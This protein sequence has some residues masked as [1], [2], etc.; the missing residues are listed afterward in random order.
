MAEARSRRS[1]SDQRS[2]WVRAGLL[3]RRSARP[4]DK[5]EVVLSPLLH[6]E[7]R[8]QVA[9]DTRLLLPWKVDGVAVEE[10]RCPNVVWPASM[11]YVRR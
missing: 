3:R 7:P 2:R 11:K 6:H 9:L 1:R 8:R 4:T 5:S 10:S